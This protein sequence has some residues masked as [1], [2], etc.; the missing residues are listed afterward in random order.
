MFNGYFKFK[1]IKSV[2]NVRAKMT[3]QKFFFQLQLTCF[4]ITNL[5]A[6]DNYLV[7]IKCIKCIETFKT[8]HKSKILNHD[9][10]SSRLDFFHIKFS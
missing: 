10:T 4:N 6:I 9:H 7:I 3:F 8:I 2:W 1:S 5:I